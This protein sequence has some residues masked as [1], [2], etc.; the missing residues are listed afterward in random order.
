[1]FDRRGPSGEIQQEKV[2]ND[3]ARIL[4]YVP[5]VEVIRELN[6]RLEQ[7]RRRGIAG[8]TANITKKILPAEEVVIN[9]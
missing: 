7:D 3:E 6:V 8:R 2:I 5:A 1:M 9:V 4:V